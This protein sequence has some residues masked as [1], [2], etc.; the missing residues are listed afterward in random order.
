MK[1]YFQSFKGHLLKVDLISALRTTYLKRLRQEDF[2]SY[3]F[4]LTDGLFQKSEI[5]KIIN[6]VN[7][8][9]Q[10]GMNTFGIGLDIYPKLIE[11]FF[12]Q[13]IYCKPNDII[14]VI[15]SFLGDNISRIEDKI[16]RKEVNIYNANEFNSIQSDL[17]KRIDSPIFKDLKNEL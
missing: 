8:C 2:P 12:P 17:I 15:A 14:K 3:L 13:I 11:N 5:N 16:Y 7:C 4:V 10:V 6:I 9:S 1:V